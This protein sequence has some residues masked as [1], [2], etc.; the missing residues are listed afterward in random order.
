[1][2]P[3]SIAVG[4]LGVIQA[5][6]SCLKLSKK[7]I[8]PSTVSKEELALITNTLYGF[9]GIMRSFQAHLEIWDDDDDRMKSLEYLKPA[10][11]QCNAA[12]EVIKEYVKGSG[13]E[14]IL[15]GVK[16]DKKLKV[17][18]AS[19]NSARSLFEMAIQSDQQ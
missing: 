16:F 9:H 18:L 8:G 10:V 3:F 12:V 2:D 19:I 11:T 5:V 15:R 7:F 6:T 14:K 13:V 4:V 1:M 17:A